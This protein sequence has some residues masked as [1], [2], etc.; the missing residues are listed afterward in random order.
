[1][2]YKPIAAAA[3]PVAVLSLATACSSSAT[4]ASSAS[5][6]SEI[7]LMVDTVMSPAASIGGLT[8]PY[9]YQAAKAAAAD[10]NEHGGIGGHKLVI[11]VCDN[12]GDP[13]QSAACGRQA[14]ANGDIAVIGS[15]DPIGAGQILPVLQAEGIPYIG[16]LSANPAELKN[17]MSFQFDPGALI[18]DFAVGQAWGDQGCKSVA[19]FN[20]EGQ[21]AAGAAALTALKQHAQN[22]GIRF[23]SVNVAVG[24]PDVSAPVSTALSGKPD[25]VSYT[26]DG[27]TAAKILAALKK[28]G[29]KGQF[30][31]STAA[32]I[33]PIVATL[34]PVANGVKAVSDGLLSDSSDPMVAKFRSDLSRSLS[35]TALASA[36]TEFGQV[37]WSSVQ[38]IKQVLTGAGSS[39]LTSAYILRKLPTMCNVNVGNF[40]PH[41]SFCKPAVQS[42]LFPRVFNTHVRYV[43]AQGGKYV[44]L[45]N[46]WHNV[47]SVVP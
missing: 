18:G 19:Y 11:D 1:M 37:G 9:G 14:K 43:T 42:K 40:Y 17:P 8:F 22:T 27:Q 29:Y 28:A 34:G 12:K 44:P 39:D 35:G 23:S 3:A 46:Q 15:F 41:I 31:T 16:S 4:G 5:S 47:A 25:C 13:N 38:L 7:R 2:R 24:Q 20:P 10:I 6:S 36:L 30:L 21:G 32:L 33:P 45:D 26:A